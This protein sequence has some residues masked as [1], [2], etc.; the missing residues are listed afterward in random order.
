VTEEEIN[1]S[2]SAPSA[3]KVLETPGAA[4]VAAPTAADT[5]D[6]KDNN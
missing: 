3:T 1:G 6:T 5:K 4:T 2:Y